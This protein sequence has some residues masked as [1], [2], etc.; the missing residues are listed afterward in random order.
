MHLKLVPNPSHLEAVNPV[1]EGFSRAK[2]DLLY[3]SDYDRILPLSSME[4]VLLQGKVL[5]MKPYSFLNYK[6]LYRW[7]YS[8]VINNQIGF[9][10]NFEDARSST[11][12]TAAASLVQ[13]PVFHVNGDDPEAVIFV[14][15]LAVEYRHC[16]T[17]MSSLIWFATVVMGIMKVMIPSLPSLSC[18]NSLKIIKILERSIY[19]N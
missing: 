1:M 11:Y 6:V 15:K 3:D 2:A 7:H 8:F 9:T 19:H 18:M 10:T 14:C 12:S 16:S 13:A 17:M 5:F 4:I